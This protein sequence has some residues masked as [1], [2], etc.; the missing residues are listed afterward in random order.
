MPRH[1]VQLPLGPGAIVPVTLDGGKMSRAD[2]DVRPPEAQGERERALTAARDMLQRTFGYPRFRGGQED[3]VAGAI[4][5]RDV[6][7]LI[8]TGGGKSLCYQ[9]PALV[10]SGLTLIV[11]P[12]ISLMTDQVDALARR[13]VAAAALHS[14]LSPGQVREHMARAETGALRMLYVAPERLESASF[15]ER[16]P[17]LR[18]GLLAVDEAHCISQWGY[19]FRPSYLR[20]GSLRD[21]LHCP[22]I[23]LTATATPAVRD[24][25]IRRMRLHDPVVIKGGFDRDNLSWHVLGVRDERHR[26][27]LLL[28]L[29]RL[30]RDGVAVV[31]GPTR[32]VVDRTADRLNGAGLRAAAYHAGVDAHERERLQAAFMNE[33]MRVIVATNA[34][35]MGIDK[36][37]VRMVAH[38]SMPSNLEGYYQEAGRGGRDGGPAACALLYNY[39]DRRTHQFFI[40][41]TYPP[42]HVIEAAYGTLL[43]RLRRGNGGPVSIVE[44]AAATRPP[45]DRRQT[46]SAL[47]IL[48]EAGLLKATPI[49]VGRDDQ[50][51]PVD[52][53]T[54]PLDIQLEGAY[55]PA[56]LPL[57]WAG[58]RAR[59]EREFHRLG[60][61]QGYAFTDRCRRGYVLDY[62]GD[63]DAMSRCTG[64]DVCLAPRKLLPGAAAPLRP[65]LTARLRERIEALRRT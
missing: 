39:R 23:A 20:L 16:L 12:L 7:V 11:S 33:E 49:G 61:M 51:D 56:R 55:P 3:A 6:L 28:A 40:E 26:Y 25:I 38:V 47:R 30:P 58:L 43:Q 19:D 35:G 37:N 57:D 13:G 45:A 65:S 9:V 36:P 44:I 14:G 8:P 63:P 24:D 31:Y 42:R 10:R 50:A 52:E 60:C 22:V 1:P 46:A 15:R 32:R 4:M 2:A 29:L 17:G 5:G 59:R 48:A 21:I 18:I 62:F 34:F 54:R 53:A 64:C 27:E 41:Q